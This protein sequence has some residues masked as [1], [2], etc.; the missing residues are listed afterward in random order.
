VSLGGIGE[1]VIGQ[2]KVVHDIRMREGEV[3][4][5]AGLSSQRQSKTVTGIPGLSGIPPIGR[6]FSGSSVDRSQSELTIAIVPHAVRRPEI[7][8]DNLR[9]IAAGSGSVIKLNYAPR[10]RR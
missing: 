7:S 4:L 3:N 10:E 8:S 1:P 6:L 9:G 2:R 5:L